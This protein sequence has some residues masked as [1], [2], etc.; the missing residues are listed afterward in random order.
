MP[1]AAKKAK[2]I[3]P[4]G[5]YVAW[6]VGSCDIDGMQHT[7]TTGER[8]RGSDPMVMAHPWLF[9]A[10]GTPEGERPTV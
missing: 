4:D 2:D 5:I 6:Q 7:V 1:R 9:V 3:A 8:R 10:D